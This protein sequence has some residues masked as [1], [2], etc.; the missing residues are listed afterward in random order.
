M[1]VKIENSCVWDGKE[2]GAGS[3]IDVPSDIVEKNEWMVPT[4]EALKDVPYKADEPAKEEK[5]A[6]P[7]IPASPATPN[8]KPG[9]KKPE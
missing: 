7:A 9:D 1:K 3:V 5:A 4:D 6:E 8:A 2:R